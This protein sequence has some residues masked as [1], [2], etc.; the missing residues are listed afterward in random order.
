MSAGGESSRRW[1]R[2]SAVRP[3][4]PPL[5]PVRLRPRRPD[6]ALAMDYA[7]T[8]PTED[9][10]EELAAALAKPLDW[11]IASVVAVVTCGFFGLFETANVYL[12]Q[13]PPPSQPAR[14]LLT[15]FLQE[16]PWWSTW[17]LVM[18]LVLWLTQ[19][20]RFDQ[21]RVRRSALTHVVA[22]L[23]LSFA[24]IVIFAVLVH[25]V[26][27]KGPM[28]P[29]G[30]QV[31]NFTR[32][33]W[34]QDLMTYYAAV[35]AYYA[36][37]YFSR[38]RRTAL[39][40]ALAD[41]RAAKLQLNLA[42]ARLHVLRMELNPHFLFNALNAVAG[43]V[44][45][46]EHDA[47]IDMLAKLGELLRTTLSREMPS[48]IPLSEELGI[49]RGFVDIEL[50]RFGERLRVV[51]EIDPDTQNAL[52]P[53]LILQPLVEN[54]IRHGISR[55]PGSALLRISAK[56]TGLHLE[57]SVRDTGEGL[58]LLR[59]AKLREGIGLSN[60]RLRLEQLYGSETTLLELTD[61]PGGGALARL[62][63]PFHLTSAHTHVALGA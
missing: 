58:A 62:L 8:S 46:R 12:L 43:L 36:F 11:R 34:F 28:P 24:H 13:Q 55:R 45:R 42:E 1:A 27:G 21:D 63:L 35:G 9:T 53:A 6:V 3:V 54:A 29:L 10:K 57:L 41:E 14:S 4:T 33:Y 60:T 38:Y 5:F 49:L 61:A 56:H 44:R 17:M 32:A 15:V 52:V 7:M 20:I 19:H 16:V 25:Y 47:A 30:M 37:D 48:E 31:K 59:G 51:W 22:G 23:G 26:T 39:A 50:V 40:A 18:P 2:R